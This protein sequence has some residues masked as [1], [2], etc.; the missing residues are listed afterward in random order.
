[1]T[2]TNSN[3]FWKMRTRYKNK[4]NIIWSRSI[5]KE[6]SRMI[7]ERKNLHDLNM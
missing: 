1:M 3:T 5:S 7:D 4:S 6:I 2:T